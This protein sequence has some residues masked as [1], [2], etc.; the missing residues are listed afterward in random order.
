M[1]T[2]AADHCG[3]GLSVDWYLGKNKQI[4]YVDCY[5]FKQQQQ[6]QQQQQQEQKNKQTNKQTNKQQQQQQHQQQQQQQQQQTWPVFENIQQDMIQ[7]RELFHRCRLR[8]PHGNYL[9]VC[10]WQRI[11]T[12]MA[13][14]K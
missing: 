1:V 3:L 6:Q 7:Q 12:S 4:N 10:E 2:G 14:I 5:L 13:R 9:A 8:Y 11:L